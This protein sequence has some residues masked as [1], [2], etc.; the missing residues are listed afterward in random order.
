M[1]FK[2]EGEI[3]WVMLYRRE[4]RHVMSDCGDV[5]CGRIFEV[6]GFN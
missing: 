4:V 2:A 3:M 1:R 6:L 5:E